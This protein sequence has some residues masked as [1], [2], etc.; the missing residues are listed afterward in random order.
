MF[1]DGSGFFWVLAAVVGVVL[2]GGALAR[3]LA[4]DEDVSAE[5]RPSPDDERRHHVGERRDERRAVSA[6]TD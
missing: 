4:G 2:L 1:E 5:E 6:S 3:S